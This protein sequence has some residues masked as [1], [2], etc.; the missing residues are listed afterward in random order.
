MVGGMIQKK[1]VLPKGF[2]TG[3]AVDW[4]KGV[5]WV[6]RPERLW[7]WGEVGGGG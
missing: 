7:G 5:E 3:G 6:G 4:T 2:G 1:G